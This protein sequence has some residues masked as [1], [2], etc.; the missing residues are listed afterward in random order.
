MSAPTTDLPFLDIEGVSAGYGLRQP[1]LQ[2]L[3][4]RV[5]SPALVLVEGENGAGKSTLVEVVSGYLTP[6]SGSITIRGVDAASPSA[7]AVRRICRTEPSLYPVMTVRDH[8]TFASRWVGIAPAA[9]ELRATRY[10]LLPWFNTP[11]GS[12]STGN[13]RKLWLVMCTL[14]DVDLVMLDEPFNG[15]DAEGIALLTDELADWARTRAVLLVAHR[16]PAGLNINQRFRL[17]RVVTADP[18]T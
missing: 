12:L 7:A 17:E 16:P 2:E 11:A 9:G 18:E 6:R 15:L 14:G 3:H 13:R 8:I 1:V 10:G 5:D 4:F